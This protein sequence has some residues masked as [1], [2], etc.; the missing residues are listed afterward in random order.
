MIY[1]RLSDGSLHNLAPEFYAALAPSKRAGLR[2]WVA[3]AAPTP[4]ATQTVAPAAPVI[5]DTT[6]T[7]AWTLVDKPAEQVASEQEA[8]QIRAILTA[9]KNGAGTS[10][11]RMARV[12]RVLFRVAKELLG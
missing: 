8:G 1:Y 7:Q 9:L 11:E 4:S 5:T 6:A 12:E 2:E 3:V 10:A